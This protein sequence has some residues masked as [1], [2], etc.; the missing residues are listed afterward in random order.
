MEVGNVENELEAANNTEEIN[1]RKEKYFPVVNLVLFIYSIVKLIL[2]FIVKFM[3]IFMKANYPEYSEEY[4]K[5]LII[6]DIIIRFFSVLL[7]FFMLKPIK[8]RNW[9]GTLIDMINI[10]LI[11]PLI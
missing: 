8:K 10:W 11:Y 6:I 2:F 9:K 5:D 4:I 3:Q 7:I 1:K